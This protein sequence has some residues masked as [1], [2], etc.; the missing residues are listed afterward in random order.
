MQSRRSIVCV[1]A[2]T[3]DVEAVPQLCNQIFHWLGAKLW[4]ADKKAIRCPRGKLVDMTVKR[5]AKPCK[6]AEVARILTLA[7]APKPLLI[8]ST[9]APKKP[10]K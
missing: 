3:G 4:F 8:T 6:P 2:G 9:P 10:R 5:P 7:A 1:V